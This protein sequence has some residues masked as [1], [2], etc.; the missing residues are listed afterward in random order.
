MRGSD[1]AF[2]RR[3]DP[4][5]SQDSRGG[6]RSWGMR[7]LHDPPKIVS[8]LKNVVSQ[9]DHILFISKDALAGFPD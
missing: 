3:G 5:E 9:Q 4:P 6:T 2:C 1:H 7:G 8:S